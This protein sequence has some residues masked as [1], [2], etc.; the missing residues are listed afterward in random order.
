KKLS[1]LITIRDHDNFFLADEVVNNIMEMD[2]NG[3]PLDIRIGEGVYLGPGVKLNAGVNIEKNARLLGNII[4]GKGVFI[5]DSVYMNTNP[6]Q[7]I[8]I[9]DKTEILQGN[10]IKGNVTIGNDCRIE[11]PV[12]LTGSD[13]WP[14]KIGNNVRIKG[15]T[16][17]FGSIVEN[18]ARIENSVLSKK[19]VKFLK[20]KQGKPVKVGYIFPEP[21]GRECLEYL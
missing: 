7:T 4:L 11:T 16:Y 19:K 14:L 15:T 1:K 20:D 17:I 12:R 8:S 21:Q 9:G 10:I 18:G 2:K 5:G 6:D 3:L 13:E